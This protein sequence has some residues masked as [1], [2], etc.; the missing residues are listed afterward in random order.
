MQLSYF[1]FFQEKCDHYWPNSS[2][3]LFYGDIQVAILNETVFPD[4]TI[5]EFKVCLVSNVLPDWTIK[6]YRVCL[7]SNVFPDWTITEFRVCLVSN[8]FPDWTI[9]EFKVCLV[10]YMYFIGQAENSKSVW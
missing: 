1:S 3:A 6:E 8:V 2:D 4:W 5:T 10:S 9:T 7:V